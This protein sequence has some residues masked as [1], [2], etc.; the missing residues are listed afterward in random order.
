MGTRAMIQIEGAN[1]AKIYKHWDGCPEHM[2]PWLEKFAAE[3]VAERPS[4]AEYMFAQLLRSSVTMCEEFKLDK[5]TSTGW[6]IV[7]FGESMGAE[8]FY[9][10]NPITGSVEVLGM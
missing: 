8:Y 3:F 4:D 1:Y 6:G 9:R 2:L 10:I 7:P 5:S